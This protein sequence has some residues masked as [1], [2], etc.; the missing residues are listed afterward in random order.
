MSLRSSP[1]ARRW[2]VLTAGLFFL[3]LCLSCSPQGERLHK[4]TRLSLYTIVTITVASD[5]DEKAAKAI[6]SAFREMERVA[7]LLNYYSPESELSL[8]N[9]SAGIRP[10]KVSPETMEIMERALFVARSTEGAFDVTMG[11]VIA[12]WDFQKKVAPE[13]EKL[14]EAL[15]RVGYSRIILDRSNSTVYLSGKGMEINLGG[16][17]K[18]YLADKAVATL[19]SEGIKAGIIAIGGDIKAFG[20]KPGGEPWTVGIQ[21][22]RQKGGSDEVIATIRLSD[23]AVSTAGDYEKFFVKDGEWYHHILDPRTGYP[24]YGCR[25]VTVLSAEGV[26]ADGIDTG[27]FIMGPQ[28]GM[29]LLKRL[30]LE[31]VI[32]DNKGAI[33]MTDGMKDKIKLL[34]EE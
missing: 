32:L 10:V 27:I 24:A 15:R 18:G 2:G 28:R 14:R 8:I 4:E 22:P 26:M 25:S 17:I 5:S 16:I 20:K 12:L 13:V 1:L 9:R 6:D 7:G 30:G 11:P 21:N 3:L 23:T 33:L 19:K 31:G 29:E 34:R